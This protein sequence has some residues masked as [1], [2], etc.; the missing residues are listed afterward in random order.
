MQAIEQFKQ[1][2]QGAGL[3]PPE[4][5][6][7]DGHIHRFSANGK[8]GDKAGWYSFH[9]DGIPAGAFGDWRQGL[10]QTWCSK[11]GS[12][13]TPEERQAHQE[14]MQAMQAQREAERAKVQA[15]AA[16]SARTLW[17]KASPC[18][19]HP[20]LTAKGVQ[21]HGV[22]EFGGRLLIP[23]RDTTATLH[24][25]QTITQDGQKRFHAGGRM[26]GCYY[27]IG[28]PDGR[29]AVCE[30][31]ATGASIHEATG[32][33]VACAM[34]AGN[35]LAVAQAL[36]AKY[37]ALQIV[38]CADDDCHTEGNP[39]LTKA[40][41]AARAVGGLIAIP[42]F[43]ADRPE[44][45]TDFND[46]HQLQ[47]LEA[48]KACLDA[49]TAPQSASEGEANTEVARKVIL[50][51]AADLQPEAI[52]WL[53]H[54]WLALGKFHLLAGAP[55]V[56]K[57]TLTMAMA[58]TVSMG[59][60][61]PDGSRCEPGKVLIWSGEDDVADTLLPRLIAAGA[62][63]KNC[64]FIS[65]VEQKGQST[66]FNLA[67]DMP[68][69]KTAV[70]Q[71]GGIRLLIVD[72]VA[73]AVTGDSHKGNE[74]RNGLQPLVDFAA[75]CN[76]A[77]LGITHFGKGGQGADPT[78]RVLGSVAFTAVARVVLVA[79]KTKDAEGR[80]ARVIARSK[81]NVTPD[82]G[83]YHYH[84]EQINV[85][86]GIETTAILW[87]DKVEGTAR[88][89]LI[90]PD[91]GGD[92]ESASDVKELLLDELTSDCWANAGEVQKAIMKCGFTS[93]QIWNA[94]KS[95]KVVRKGAGF[96]KDK[97]WYWRLPGGEEPPLPLDSTLDSGV[98]LDSPL[99][100]ASG[101]Y[102]GSRAST[103]FEGQKT[104]LDSAGA[105]MESKQHDAPLDSLDSIFPENGIYGE[106]KGQK[107]SIHA[108]SSLDSIAE[109]KEESKG[110]AE[111]KQNDPENTPDFVEEVL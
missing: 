90:D 20:Y 86:G 25:L 101:I 44:K 89:L 14:R 24:S 13:M 94:S 62:N 52:R 83:G 111:S 34:T 92:Q 54:G 68:I 19:C 69:L 97:K 47:G 64:H 36:H 29:V 106:K 85:E 100:S 35:L 60:A 43:G 6:H 17:D 48:V 53:W 103:G 63:L 9:A 23:L 107:P 11:E 51:S 75:A 10:E 96:G 21:G 55:G 49:A 18:T 84:L 78:S 76:C 108:G 4:V 5:I 38:V 57:T 74:V 58:A 102:A 33:A 72:P 61:W 45:A 46:L 98:P 66:P 16:Q 105:N 50:T 1:A 2:M 95:L 7:A 82:D 88:E 22:K 71:L 8:H 99:D 77:V 59:G 28:K 110:G 15:E 30:G 93:K 80:P 3:P 87:G 26:Q 73:G 12:S 41:E 109:S 27:A 32:L 42:Q 56:G 104:P 91:A 39:G 31:Y 65:G 79:A 81:G 37:P 70:Q 40:Q 67:R